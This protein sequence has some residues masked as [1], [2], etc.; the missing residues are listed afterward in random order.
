[1]V[2]LDDLYDL[3]RE[4]NVKRMRAKFQEEALKR[5]ASGRTDG[6]ESYYLTTDPK[7]AFHRQINREI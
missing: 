6:K 5:L 3:P 7:I 2:R 4:D 1:M